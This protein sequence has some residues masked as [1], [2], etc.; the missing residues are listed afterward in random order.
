MDL[1]KALGFESTPQPVS[2]NQRD[3]L[4]YA[5]GVSPHALPHHPRR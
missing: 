1:D 2:W 3:A 5:A 4:I